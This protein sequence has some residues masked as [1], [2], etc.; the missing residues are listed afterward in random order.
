MPFNRPC[1]KCGT[2]TRNT[3]GYCDPHLPVKVESPERRA[4]KKH[5][6]GGEYH[7]KAKLIR[8]NSTHC[9]LCGKPFTDGEP[10]QADHLYPQL[11][12]QS[13]LGAT[14]PHCNRAKGDHPHPP[15]P[16]K[17]L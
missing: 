9:Y 2:L 6:Y 3:R 7:A 17:T 15:H 14:H 12:S 11:G 8:E 13:P 1:L 16:P 5:L 10:I 4:K